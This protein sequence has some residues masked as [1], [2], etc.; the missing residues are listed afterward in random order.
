ML[1]TTDTVTITHSAADM[2]IHTATTTTTVGTDIPMALTNRKPCPM[3]LN[4]FTCSRSRVDTGIHMGGNNATAMG[5]KG[6]IRFSVLRSPA[7]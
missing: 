7:Y 5:T 3:R 6:A 1:T 4:R 2:G